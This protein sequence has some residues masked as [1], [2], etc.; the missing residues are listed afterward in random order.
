MHERCYVRLGKKTIIQMHFAV[1]WFIIVCLFHV[2]T[3]PFNTMLRWTINSGVVETTSLWM[4]QEGVGDIEQ[5][6]DHVSSNK[7]VI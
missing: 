5:L 4:E 2:Y 3:H 7:G 6:A 1:T